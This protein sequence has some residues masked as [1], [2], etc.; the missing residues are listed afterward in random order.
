MIDPENAE[1]FSNE[2]RAANMIVMGVTYL[3]LEGICVRDD[4]LRLLDFANAVADL[5]GRAQ[6]SAAQV[7][8]LGSRT[9]VPEMAGEDSADL[10]HKIVHTAFRDPE[11]RRR[12][13]KETA[14]LFPELATELQDRTTS[15]EDYCH[16][17]LNE[18]LIGRVRSASA[19]R[20]KYREILISETHLDP[21]HVSDLREHLLS[22]LTQISN[23]RD[24]LMSG[25]GDLPSSTRRLH[26]MLARIEGDIE[27]C[28]DALIY[29]GQVNDSIEKARR[30]SR[31][32][33]TESD[34]A[35]AE[36][37][38]LRELNHCREEIRY[39]LTYLSEECDRITAKDIL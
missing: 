23:S 36:L 16:S 37:I 22:S 34:Q 27:S 12:L 35:T 13:L 29:F 19:L 17:S 26:S 2:G 24:V 25:S 11:L 6:P 10:T 31:L 15:H 38:R 39:R 33:I 18:E 21:Q 9:G 4:E 3:H 5:I 14:A 30:N 32:G 28:L 1:E 7:K 8:R 20:S